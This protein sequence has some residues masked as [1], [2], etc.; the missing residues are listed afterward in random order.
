MKKKISCSCARADKHSSNCPIRNVGGLTADFSDV[1]KIFDDLTERQKKDLKSRNPKR[2]LKILKQLEKVWKKNPNL[3]L[4]QLIG[5]AVSG[6]VYNCED[7][8]LIKKLEKF[9]RKGK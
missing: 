6:N 2:I 5:N 4:G 8:E 9:Y 7:D 1:L 3:R